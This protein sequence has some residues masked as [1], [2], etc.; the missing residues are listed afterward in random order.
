[1]SRG[2]NAGGES[3]SRL[4]LSPAQSD[5]TCPISPVTRVRVPLATVGRGINP[6][7]LEE[8]ISFGILKGAPAYS[9][10]YQGLAPEGR[11]RCVAAGKGATAYQW[12]L[13]TTRK[14]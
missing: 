8:A 11:D 14:E 3:D 10:R 5:S 6:L 7:G 12:G 9:V 4:V 13:P 2:L 1:M